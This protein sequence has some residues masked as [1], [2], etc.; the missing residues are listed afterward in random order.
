MTANGETIINK[1][2][3]D[4]LEEIQNAIDTWINT[5]GNTLINNWLSETAA[6]TVNQWLTDNGNSKI[7]EYVNN[8]MTEHAGEIGSGQ[9]TEW[10]EQNGQTIITTWL[11]QQDL[12]TL[13]GNA[14][15]NYFESDDFAQ[16]LADAIT[17]TVQQY[18]TEHLN[19]LLG[20]YFQDIQDAITNNERVIANALSRHE[21]DILNVKE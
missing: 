14:V 10:L 3:E 8:Y 21:E 5:N 4:H 16:Q 1:Y 11:G 7:E 15:S 9:I 2:L 20:D 18:L 17:P 13:V 6:N 12:T 19:E